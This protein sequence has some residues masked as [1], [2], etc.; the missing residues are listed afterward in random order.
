ML[1]LWLCEKG[2]GL[3]PG[4]IDLRSVVNKVGV[5]LSEQD[6]RGNLNLAGCDS[7]LALFSTAI[8]RAYGAPIAPMEEFA[9]QSMHALG[10]PRR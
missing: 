3:E 9:K 10:G 2:L 7:H 6:R 4:N 8:L 5:S 1:G